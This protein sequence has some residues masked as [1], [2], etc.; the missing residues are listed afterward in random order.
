MYTGPT[1]LA[2]AVLPPEAMSPS[3]TCP[4]EPSATS[5]WLSLY[6]PES[7]NQNVAYL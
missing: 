3:G 7:S 6:E 5:V 1:L 2:E 4:A